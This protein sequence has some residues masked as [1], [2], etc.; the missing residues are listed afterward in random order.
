MPV[1]LAQLQRM[2]EEW[3][4]SLPWYKR[5]QVKAGLIGAGLMSLGGALRLGDEQTRGP[6]AGSLGCVAIILVI[7]FAIA[8]SIGIASCATK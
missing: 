5:W 6:V 3:L 7:I 8:L 2:L 4:A 1:D